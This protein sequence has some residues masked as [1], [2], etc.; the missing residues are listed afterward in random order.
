MT[1]RLYY[2][3]SYLTDFEATVLERGEGGRLYLDR[4]AFYPTSGGQQFDRGC[5]RS[6]GEDGA[7]SAAVDVVDVVDEGERVAHLLGEGDAP[8]FEP[9]ARV[10]GQVDW[11]RRFDHMQQHSGQHLLSAVFQEL[12]GLATSSVHFGIEASTLDLDVASLSAEQIA[13]VEERVNAIVFENRPLSVDTEDAAAAQGLRKQSTRSGPLRIVSI[14][15]LDRSACGGTH[16][17]RTGEIG[18]V[19]MRKLER[20]RKATRVEFVCGGRATRR[21]RADY[22]ALSKLGSLLSTSVDSV[23]DSVALRL[24]ELKRDTAA[25]RE[26]RESLA[27]YRAIELYVAA[28]EKAAG[29]APALHL[30]RRPEGS[31][32]DERGLA[33]AYVSNPNAV[34]I[35][36]VERPASILL[37][38]SEDTGLDAGAILKAA[39]AVAGGRGGGSARLAQGTVPSESALE[40]ASKALLASIAPNGPGEVG[41]KTSA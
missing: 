28:R 32:Q 7:V 2:D 24:G 26:A 23:V 35:L 29:G 4:S 18:P 25:L 9:G 6:A 36:T 41:S 17:K 34:F 10:R 37:A 13:R 16:V 39:L 19:M 11:A 27:G 1:Q 21:A 33:Q 8:R 30:E 40:E 22:E 5:L 15:A 38:T 31:L 3:D 20:V 12:L 14:A